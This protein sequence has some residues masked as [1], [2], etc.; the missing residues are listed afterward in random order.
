MWKR[1]RLNR[2]S[3]RTTGEI[4]PCVPPQITHDGPNEANMKCN[5]WWM[6]FVKNVF[7]KNLLCFGD[8]IF[9]CT[10]AGSQ[11]SSDGVP[12]RCSKMEF[13]KNWILRQCVILILF[14][15][16]GL[17]VFKI[18]SAIQSSEKS[19]AC[20]LSFHHFLHLNSW[21]TSLHMHQIFDSCH[22][23]KKALKTN[24]DLT[25]IIFQKL[26]LTKSASIQASKSMTPS[27]WP[28]MTAT[29]KIMHWCK[30]T[31]ILKMVKLIFQKQCHFSYAGQ[32]WLAIFATHFDPMWAGKTIMLAMK[33]VGWS[34]T[35]RKPSS[36][37]WDTLV[38]KVSKWCDQ[39]KHW[40]WLPPFLWLWGMA[41]LQ[42][43]WKKWPVVPVLSLAFL[44][45][46]GDSETITQ[47]VGM[48]CWW[49]LV[50]HWSHIS[51]LLGAIGHDKKEKT[52]C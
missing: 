49:W 26:P 3:H 18:Q 48:G 39:L 29:P 1:Y 42:H 10:S 13:F 8:A 41:I 33:I 2:V 52:D 6:F 44:P 30:Q 21:K 35:L 40:H 46:T 19:N 9:C 22:N 16:I 37:S 45:Q 20:M 5:E 28:K 31:Q 50:T 32:L 34:T 47:I 23:W 25:Q 4:S 27:H 51:H 24:R 36:E 12:L 7:N 11:M 17:F 14:F 15:Q 43:W 38:A